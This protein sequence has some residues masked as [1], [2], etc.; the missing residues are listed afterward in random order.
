LSPDITNSALPACDPCENDKIELLNLQPVIARSCPAV[1]LIIDHDLGFL[2][3][4]GEV[5]AELGCQTVPALHCLEALALSKRLRLAVTTLVVNPELPG[6]AR[7]VKVLLSVNPEMQVA[8]IFD[9]AA[10]RSRDGASGRV[11]RVRA[12]VQTRFTLERPAPW[13]SISRDEWLAKV[14][15]VVV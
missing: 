2:M 10:H 6:A 12:C 3:W 14:R 15:E 11:D 8:L 7:L 9:S 1:V 5:F 13:E 4:L